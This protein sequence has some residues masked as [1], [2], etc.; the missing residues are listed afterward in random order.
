MTKL[1]RY[2]FLLLLVSSTASHAWNLDGYRQGFMLS[3]GGGF[4]G[5]RATFE[6]DNDL[7]YV[8]NAGS[9]KSYKKATTRFGLATTAKIGV[10]LLDQ[11][12][13]HYV[14]YAA[15]YESR[16]NIA[17][18]SHRSDIYNGFHGLGLSYYF[19]KEAPSMYLMAAAGT[20]QMRTPFENKPKA[21]DGGDISRSANGDGTLLAI[22]WEVAR[23]HSIEFAWQRNEFGDLQSNSGNVDIEASSYYFTYNYQFY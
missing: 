13:L 20:A 18:F 9:A 11:L 12:A 6:S 2:S 8:D 5:T 15:W 17:V 4:Q 10:G 1:L 23:H 22:G 21:N 16:D 19:S 3:L 14:F 7:R